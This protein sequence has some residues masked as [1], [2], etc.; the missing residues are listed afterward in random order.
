KRIMGTIAAL[1]VLG[2]TSLASAAIITYDVSG[3]AA[4]NS[5]SSFASDPSLPPGTTG[6]D[7]VFGPFF[8]GKAST[9]SSMTINTDTNGDSVEGDVSLVGGTLKFVGLN[10]PIGAL[11]S[12]E[13]NVV[14]TA[15]GGLGTLTGNTINW[16][17]SGAPGTGTF[18]NV[19][20]T[21][22]CHGAGLCG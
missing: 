2:Y 7:P 20:G 11:G 14:A 10:T 12:I 6:S 1:G 3:V 8:I 21:W 13:T 15:S 17:M 19:T 22:T 16:D 5:V 9:G 4:V 18:W